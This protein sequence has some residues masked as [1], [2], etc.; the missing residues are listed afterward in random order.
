MSI[1]SQPITLQSLFGTNRSIGTFV[2]NV[3]LNEE[4]TDTLTVTKQP[5]QKGTPITDHSYQEPTVLSMNIL[6]QNNTGLIPNTTDLLG[7]FGAAGSNGLAQIYKKFQDLQSSR[8]PFTVTTIKRVYENMLMTSLRCTTD[9]NT[10]N[11][12]SLGL[13]FQQVTFVDVGTAQISPILQKA[14]GTTQATQNLG[15]QSFA[16]TLA[17][18]I[19]PGVKL[20]QGPQ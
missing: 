16:A 13:S 10:E 2:V 5:V 9:K 4:T 12:L 7:N 11:I 3:T 17:Q 1:L 6:Q 14:P 18:K 20:F 8:I 19:D 15:K